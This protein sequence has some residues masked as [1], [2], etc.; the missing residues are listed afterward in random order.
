MRDHRL[1]LLAQQLDEAG[2]LLDQRID[3]GGFAIEM[4]QAL[5]LYRRGRHRHRQS[6]GL[7]DEM[8]AEVECSGFDRGP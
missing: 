7:L 8:D 2:L 1:P 4:R 3:P 5:M 6:I